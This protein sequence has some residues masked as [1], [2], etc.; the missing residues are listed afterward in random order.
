MCWFYGQIVFGIPMA[1]FALISDPDSMSSMLDAQ[2]QAQTNQ[3]L[4]SLSFLILFA[5]PILAVLLWIFRNNFEEKGKRIALIFAASQVVLSAIAFVYMLTSSAGQTDAQFMSGMISSSPFVYMF[6]LLTFPPLTIGLWLG[7]KHIHGRTILSLQTAFRKFRWKRLLFA[8]L[9]FWAIA[10][11]LS[12]IGHMTGNSKAEYVFDPSRFWLYLP[13]TLLF[14]PLQSATEEIALRGYL[15]QALGHYL[16]NP[17]I[18]F[19]IT[20]AG[21]AALHLGNPEIAA[22]TENTSIWI[23]I[24]GYFFFG[25]FMCVLTMIDGG[26]ES[27]IGVHAANNI[28]AASIVGYESSALPT[29]TLFKT[30]LNTE[31]DSIMTVVGLS[32]VC[33]ILYLTRTHLTA[34]EQ[35]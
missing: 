18:V 19:F 10:V 14:I 15:N 12:Y 4:N 23:A 35:P 32:L 2:M 5:S 7:Q 27:A 9:V 3:T 22:G 26:L 28:F 29:P 33:G 21:F 11:G 17:W 30:A 8:M 16:K 13:V 24:S 34:Q 1:L 20:S 25:M 6:M 31:L